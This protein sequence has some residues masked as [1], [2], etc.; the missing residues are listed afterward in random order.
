ME[1]LLQSL[2]VNSKR[3][4]LKRDILQA[5][6]PAVFLV[7]MVIRVLVIVEHLQD[8]LLQLI[9]ASIGILITEGKIH[10]TM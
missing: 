3:V 6:V 7:R 1:I 4:D 9:L 10:L 8:F 5:V 2:S